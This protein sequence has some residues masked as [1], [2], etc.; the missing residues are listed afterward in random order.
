MKIG[1]A[2]YYADVTE[3]DWEIFA[4]DLDISHKLVQTELER[5]KEYLPKI[6]E[7]LAK[8]LDCE[9]GVRIL[10]YIKNNKTYC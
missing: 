1:K 9:I 3:K 7:K 10:D 2:R 5:Q 8:E 4:Q 6:V